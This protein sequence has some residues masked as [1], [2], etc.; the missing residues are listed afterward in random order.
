MVDVFTFELI[1]DGRQSSKGNQLKW[2]NDRKW[3]KADYTGYEGL[4]EYVVSHL[5]LHSTLKA[6]EYV[7]YDT[8]QIKYKSQV[9]DGCVSDDFSGGY[10]VITVERLFKTMYG[11]SLSKNI[12]SF[13]NV[14]DRLDYLVKQVERMTGII[15]FGIYLSKLFAIDAVFLNE[16]RHT[17]NISI[18]KGDR[19]DYKLCPIYDNGAALM[20]DTTLDYPMG[21]DIFAEIDN[22]K[23]KT[24]CDDFDEQ[25][26]CAEAV[27]G[28]HLKFDFDYNDVIAIMANDTAY[29][30]ETKKRVVDIIMERRRKYKYLFS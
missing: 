12:Y 9:F 6:E 13:A 19:G 25:L 21:I 16:D 4:A 14:S 7:I 30:E 11:E 8:E 15:G 18:L 23:S 20:S 3:Y 24:L 17:H 10:S 26:E 27:Y 29:S 22:V 5:L 2:K 28:N 1:D